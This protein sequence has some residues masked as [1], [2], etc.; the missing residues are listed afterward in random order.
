[1]FGGA[2]RDLLASGYVATAAAVVRLDRSPPL[3]GA[4]PSAAAKDDD[5]VC[6]RPGKLARE[7]L[8]ARP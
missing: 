6:G 7:T 3:S 1:M 2:G 8:G 4:A 5:R